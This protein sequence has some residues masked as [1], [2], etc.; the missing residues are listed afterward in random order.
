M[1]SKSASRTDGECPECEGTLYEADFD[2]FCG[3]CGLV[4]SSSSSTDRISAWE[5]HRQNPSEHWNSGRQR[6]IGG[7]PHAY[8]W[9]SSDE[10]DGPV[11]SID[12]TQFYR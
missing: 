12:P 3:S 8:D 10:I 11:D 7:F 5:Y 4:I 2:T 1:T 6:C 9:V